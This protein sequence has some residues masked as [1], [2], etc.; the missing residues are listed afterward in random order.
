MSCRHFTH[1]PIG[2][3]KPLVPIALALALGA[4]STTGGPFASASGVPAEASAYAAGDLDEATQEWAKKL[5]ED[6]EDKSAAISLSRLLR[7]QDK[8]AHAVAIMRQSAAYHP[9]DAEVQAEFGKALADTGNAEEAE[10]VLAQAVAA[11]SGDWKLYSTYGTVLDQLKRHE[12]ARANYERALKLS[13]DEPSVLNNMGLSYALD[14]N[15][16][17]AERVLRR[18]AQQPGATRAVKE[19]LALVLGLQGKFDEAETIASKEL[20]EQQVA[21]NTTYLKQM[22]SQPSNWSRVQAQEEKNTN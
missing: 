1:W 12:E 18:A 10:K 11:S 16:T 17:Q 9:K 21:G 8:K 14:R 6:P 4:C 13:P 5:A 7:A 3:A 19:N 2:K 15:L 22:M 20:P